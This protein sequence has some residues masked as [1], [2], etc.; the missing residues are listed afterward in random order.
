MNIYI[1]NINFRKI[2]SKFP[3]AWLRSTDLLIAANN[4]I[5]SLLLF[6]AY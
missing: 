1:I 5:L 4:N 3:D 2:N 6:F